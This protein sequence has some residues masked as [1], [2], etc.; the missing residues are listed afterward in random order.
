[1]AHV[2]DLRATLAPTLRIQDPEEKKKAREALVTN[3]MPLWAARTEK[4][5]ER[6]PFFAGDKIHVVDLKLHMAVRWFNTGK[7]DHI[8][9][10]IFG[11]F[12][13]LNRVH[14]AV[15]DHA[16]VKAWNAKQAG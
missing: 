6:G 11:D 5:I 3:Y 10:T 4:Q 12:P 2:E 7:V 8:P 15:R 16:G 1:M 9:A 14:D 13:K